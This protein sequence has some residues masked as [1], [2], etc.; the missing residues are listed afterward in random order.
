[1]GSLYAALKPPTTTSKTI[2][3]GVSKVFV[4]PPTRTDYQLPIAAERRLDLFVRHVEA[5]PG[6]LI[7]ASEVSEL[8]DAMDVGSVEPTLPAGMSGEDF[9]GVLK[10]ALLTECATD[11]YAHAIASRAHAYDATWLERFTLETWAPDE[12]THHEPF[13]HMLRSLGFSDA[14]MDREMRE[15]QEQIYVHGA[16]DTPAHITAYAMIQEY[17]TDH[18]HGLIGTLTREAAPVASKMASRVKQRETLHAMWYRDMTAMQVEADPSLLSHV[19]EAVVHFHMPGK[20][21]LPELE[22]HVP[23]LLSVARA[24][25]DELVRGLIRLVESLLPDTRS[26]GALL[27]EVA[28]AKGMRF[29]PVSAGQVHAALGRLGGPGY[30]LI[31]EALLDRAGLSYLYRKSDTASRWGQGDP[32]TGRLRAMLREWV[33]SQID[34]RLGFPVMPDAAP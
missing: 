22:E 2:A 33:A 25:L 29:G 14:E 16:G 12:H 18:W 5:N 3:R 6:N 23:H 34:L 4:M 28:S 21:I 10:L 26:A 11:T 7:T 9:T 8:E 30:G 27:M 32:F 15:T 19:A 17:L 24:D 31:G 20:I 13:G 1:V